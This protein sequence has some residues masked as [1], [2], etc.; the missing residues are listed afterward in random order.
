MTIKYAITSRFAY[1][2]NF[3]HC[4][5][6]SIIKLMN[7]NCSILLYIKLLSVIYKMIEKILFRL[8]ENYVAIV[9]NI[10]YN[11]VFRNLDNIYSTLN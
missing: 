7:K 2:I 11:F 1:I 5:G 4:C 8:E 6:L 10:F 9:N 3:S